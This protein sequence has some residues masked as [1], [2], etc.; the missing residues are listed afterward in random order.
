V[1]IGTDSA[2]LAQLFLFIPE[3]VNYAKLVKSIN[4]RIWSQQTGWWLFWHHHRFHTYLLVA[5]PLL[6]DDFQR[7][8]TSPVLEN[9]VVV[10]AGICVG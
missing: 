3:I 4:S 9:T 2:V 5:R 1:E 10:Y 7:M 8:A 6:T